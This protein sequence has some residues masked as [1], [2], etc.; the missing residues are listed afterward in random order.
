M[1]I[2][3]PKAVLLSNGDNPS[4]VVRVFRTMEVVINNLGEDD[5]NI[6]MAH[7]KANAGRRIFLQRIYGRMT[8]IRAKR[9]TAEL[10]EATKDA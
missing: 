5:L 10:K 2:K 7:E 3:A 1:A 4:D 6:L 9:E 8:R